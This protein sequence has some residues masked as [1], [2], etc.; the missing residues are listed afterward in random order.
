MSARTSDQTAFSRWPFSYHNLH[1]STELLVMVVV[2]SHWPFDILL[3]ECTLS[4]QLLS[5]QCPR[6][7]F[8]GHQPQ[9]LP[10]LYLPECY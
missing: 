7:H 5:C 8:K 10:M 3:K 4:N 6:A 9:L 1:F 2:L